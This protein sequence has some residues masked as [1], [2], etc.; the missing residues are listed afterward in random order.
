MEALAVTTKETRTMMEMFVIFEVWKD[1]HV[2]F[3]LKE[4]LWVLCSSKRRQLM[5]MKAV[6][7]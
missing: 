4:A 6:F 5:N 3:G 7:L 1:L 2:V